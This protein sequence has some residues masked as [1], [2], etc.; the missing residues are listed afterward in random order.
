[1]QVLH[2][3]NPDRFRMHPFSVWKYYLLFFA[4]LLAPGIQATERVVDVNRGGDCGDQIAVKRIHRWNPLTLPQK[5]DDKFS[6]FALKVSSIGIPQPVPICTT[7][8]RD[9]SRSERP[10]RTRATPASTKPRPESE[11][12]YASAE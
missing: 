11:R 5:L 9:R 7:G 2:A 6:D 10:D 8:D 3:L 12:L 4:A 1:M